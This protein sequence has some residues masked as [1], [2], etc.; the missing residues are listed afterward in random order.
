M[1]PATPVVSALLSLLTIYAPVP[2]FSGRSVG[3][4]FIDG[5][6]EVAADP[7]ALR[8][9]RRRSYGIG[10]P[11]N[12]TPQPD[13]RP[14]VNAGPADPHGPHL[15]APGIDDAES[16]AA[17]FRRHPEHAWAREVRSP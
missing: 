5:Q 11:A 1:G 9:F 4:S 2:W 10:K 3:V 6:A 13:Y 15:V 12:A 17:Y 14:P 8:Y 7:P 16:E